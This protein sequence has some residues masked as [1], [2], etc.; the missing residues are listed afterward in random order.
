MA[1]GIISESTASTYETDPQLDVNGDVIAIVWTARQA[2]S[3]PAKIGY[4]I[5]TDGGST[6][7]DPQFIESTEDESFEAADV[8]VDNGGTTHV[9]F[10]GHKRI[11]GGA[12]VYVTTGQGGATTLPDPI[13]ITDDTMQGF[14]GPPRAALTNTVRLVVAYTETVNDQAVLRV[15]TREQTGTDWTIQDMFGGGNNVFWPTPCAAA[16]TMMGRT[17]LTYVSQGRVFLLRSDDNG[18]TWMQNQASADGDSISGPPSCVAVGQNV[19]VSYGVRANIGLDE[20]KVAHSD[21]AGDNILNVGVVS[22]P[23]A[24]P[25]F[26]LHQLAAQAPETGHLVYYNGAGLGD[27]GGSLRRVRFSPANLEPPPIMMPDDPPPGLPSVLITEPIT[28]QLIDDD[29]RWL[30]NGIGLDFAGSD[31]YVAYVDNSGDESH[32]AFKVVTP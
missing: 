16:D 15:A 5:S 32:V 22:D 19:W 28:M 2:P 20:I 18:D 25:L 29:E 14:F 27:K 7:P 21:D 13:K 31:L 11:G 24:K 3:S 1:E 23:D 4:T 26:G 9:T 6:F 12:A 30:G 8:V 17:Y 10:L